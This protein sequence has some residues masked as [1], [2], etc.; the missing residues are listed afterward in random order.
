MILA[1]KAVIRFG[2]MFVTFNM[3]LQGK[4]FKIQKRLCMF[5][6]VPLISSF[7][8]GTKTILTYRGIESRGFTGF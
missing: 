2:V 3:A 1:L 6:R 8:G 5:V 7:V 4:P